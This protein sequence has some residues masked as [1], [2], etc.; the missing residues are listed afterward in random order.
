LF[1]GAMAARYNPQ[2]K[3]FRD[4]LVAVGKSKILA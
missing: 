4:K 3:K 1:I 2:L